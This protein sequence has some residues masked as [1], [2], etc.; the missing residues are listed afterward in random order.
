[1]LYHDSELMLKV[2]RMV[3]AGWSYRQTALSLGI[4]KDKVS[5]IMQTFKKGKAKVEN[6]KVVQ[7]IPP[8]SRTRREGF[9]EGYRM[10]LDDLLKAAADVLAIAKEKW[11]SILDEEEGRRMLSF[12][13]DVHRA[14]EARLPR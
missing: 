1:M 14:L 4:S 8:A 2:Y 5:R 7:T 3:Q 13:T 11:P 9:E 6:G 10:C 12:I